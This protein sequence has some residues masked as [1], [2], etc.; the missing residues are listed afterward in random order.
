[1]ARHG[2]FDAVSLLHRSA[3]TSVWSARPAGSTAG[4][5]NHCLKRVELTDHELADHDAT[6]AEHLLVGAALQQAM[7]DKSDG[8]APVYELGTDD[9]TDAFYV[10]RLYPRSAQSMIDGRARLS[11]AE[12]RTIL[13]AVVDGLLDLDGAYGRPHANLKPTNVLLG[14]QIRAGQVHLADPGAVAANVPSLTRAPDPKAVGQLLYALVTH[15]PHTGARWPL[16]GGDAWR[17]M[18]ASGR[19]WFG[20][21][22]SL[23]NPFSDRLP[24]LTELRARIGAISPSRRR[25]PRSL[26]AVPVVAAVAAA[27]YAYRH[28]IDHQLSLLTRPTHVEHHGP[29]AGTKAAPP[30]RPAVAARPPAPPDLSATLAGLSVGPAVPPVGGSAVDPAPP[31]V[32]TPPVLLAQAPLAPPTPAARAGPATSPAAAPAVTPPPRPVPPPAAAFAAANTAAAATANHRAL[33]LVREWSS[34]DFKSDAAQAAFE[35]GRRG[36]ITAH[37]A[38]DAAVTL[39]QWEAVSTRL[40]L[41]GD[42]YPPV[43]VATT[44]G[45]PVAV[46]DQVTARR[47]QVLV[48]AVAAAFDQTS[49]DPGP[50]HKLTDAVRGAVSAAAVARRTLAGGSLPAARSAVAD[51]HDAVKGV[52]GEDPA[53]ADAM[54][55]SAADLDRLATAESSPDRDALLATA[56]DDGAPLA[57]RV[58]AWTRA[59]RVAGTKPWPADF[60]AAAAD[61]SKGLELA[62]LLHDQVATA[63]EKAVLTEADR[64][65]AVYVGSLHDQQS[66]AAAAT[67]A[68]DPQD[69]ELVARCPAWFRFD[70]ALAAA[71]HTPASAATADERHRLLDLAAA[72]SGPAGQDVIDLLHTGD[73]RAARS[74]AEA[75]P[76]ATG[77]WRLHAGSTH[78]RATYD[79]TTGR[80]ATIEFL[81]VHVPAAASNSGDPAGL[82]CYLATTAVP[83]SLVSHLLA[84]DGAA[85]ATARDLAGPA[86]DAGPR[87]WKFADDPARPVVTDGDAYRRC[88][89]VPPTDTL[90]AQRVTPALA[91]FLSRRAGCRLPSAAEWRAAVDFARQSSDPI[92]R[93]FATLGWKL[94]TAANYTALLANPARDASVQPAGGGFAAGDGVW[95][96]S[97]VARLGGRL[98]G[99]GSAA[100][101]WPLSTLETVDGFGF[102]PVGGTDDYGGVFHDLVGNVAQ[103]VLDVPATLA[104]QL[105]PTAAAADVRAWFTP[106]RLAAAAVVGGSAVSPPSVDPTRPTPLPNGGSFSDVGFRLAFTDPAAKP[107]E[108]WTALRQMPFAT[109]P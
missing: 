85:V 14:E 99:D 28:Q 33:A 84:D 101:G 94:R 48:R 59:G 62:G 11:S 92:A 4:T 9:G 96:P 107:A 24:D 35:D 18:G 103:L 64:R 41:A 81:R 17:A 76:A 34:P 7:A 57:V 27:A 37:D 75:G 49:F 95:T 100:D 87:V 19:Q 54:S 109:A 21:C 58:A 93:G 83:V 104:E 1:M 10:T 66:A 102:R 15:R 22:E 68:A 23:V 50:Y 13:M 53:V 106:D 16:A 55:A 82:D 5:P 98:A 8:W 91:L 67:A 69:A 20:L 65:L 29:A 36:F 43:D 30:A 72:A 86:G 61:Q 70:V 79:S 89:A 39:A 32:A 51:F 3:H 88:F 6:A 105:E 40:R 45:W 71:R 80:P 25:L 12:L 108:A 97:A 74:L 31:V 60:A 90:P 38:D 44:A 52:A 46:A 77:R 56:D 78:D 63:A 42:A 2:K 26:V 47:E 73:R